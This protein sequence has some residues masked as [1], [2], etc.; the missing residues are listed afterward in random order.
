MKNLRKIFLTAFVLIVVLL[1]ASSFAQQAIATPAVASSCALTVASVG[2]VLCK[3]GSLLKSVIPVLIT[4]GIVYFIWGI[5]AYVIG[6]DQEAKKK[7]KNK[8]IYGLIGFVVIF[9]LQGLVSI[10]INTFGF[11]QGGQ[12]VTNLVQNNKNI[13]EANLGSCNLVNNPKLGDVFNYATCFINSSVIPLIASLAV[14][15]FIWGIIQYVINNEEE[16]KKEKG[17]QFMIWGIIGLAVMVGVWGLVSI[18]GSTFGIKYVIPQ[19]Q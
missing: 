18:L 6:G 15:I 1:P 8:I 17:K 11:D 2:D 9:A 7:G 14:A 4:L 16:A 3:I 10:V 12:L 19:L 5:V 13:A